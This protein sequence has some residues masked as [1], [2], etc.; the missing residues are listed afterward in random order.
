MRVEMALLS[1]VRGS[2]YPRQLYHAHLTAV[3]PN[4][5][6]TGT[7]RNPFQQDTTR[8]RGQNKATC[9]QTLGG[10]ENDIQAG[11]KA[12]MQQN[13]GQLPQISPGGMISMTLHQVNADGAGPYTC[14]LFSP[15]RTPCASRK[16]LTKTTKA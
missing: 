11:T 10:G 12:V 13:G 8:F 7:T 15:F 5:P 16:T 3:D 9:G 6:R 4:T 14:K 2:D 1:A